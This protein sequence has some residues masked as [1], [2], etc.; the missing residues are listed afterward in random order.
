MVNTS[1]TSVYAT[2]CVETTVW[3]SPGWEHM[4]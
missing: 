3:R 4:L 1:V 2:C